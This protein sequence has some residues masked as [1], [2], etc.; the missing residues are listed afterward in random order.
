MYLD[1]LHVHHDVDEV[2]A[3]MEV[4]LERY[5]DADSV[6]VIEV[7]LKLSW[8]CSGNWLG[9]I[10]RSCSFLIPLTISSV[11]VPGGYERS[12]TNWKTPNTGLW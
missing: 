2:D 12:S 10:H 1:A 9:F 8:S 5:S 3:G 6:M 7:N 4:V 11:V